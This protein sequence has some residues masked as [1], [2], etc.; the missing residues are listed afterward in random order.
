MLLR[1]THPS[2]WTIRCRSLVRQNRI[3]QPPW[4]TKIS[5][6]TSACGWTRCWPPPAAKPI[7]WERSGCCRRHRG[8]ALGRSFHAQPLELSNNKATGATNCARPGQGGS[9]LLKMGRVACPNRPKRWL[10]IGRQL[11]HRLHGLQEGRRFNAY[12]TIIAIALYAFVGDFPAVGAIAQLPS[13]SGPRSRARAGED[14]GRHPGNVAPRRGLSC[15]GQRFWREKSWPGA[16][17]NWKF[18]IAW[19]WPRTP[20]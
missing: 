16:K 19:V 12:M 10:S 9:L 15:V 14:C 17:A 2:G 5:M 7:P 3:S 1:P 18:T 4:A 20:S 11:G 8:I 13:T 6:T